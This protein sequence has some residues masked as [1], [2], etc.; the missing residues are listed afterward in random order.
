M[1][2]HLDV[3]AML[4]CVPQVLLGWLGVFIVTIVIIAAI[5]LLNK[6]TTKKA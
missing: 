3:Q 5:W 4:A 1:N 2:F 6:L